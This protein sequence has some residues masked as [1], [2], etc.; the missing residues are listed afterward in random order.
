MHRRQG[1]GTKLIKMFLALADI[2]DEEVYLSAR[3]V[4]NVTKETLERLDK[5]YMRFGFTVRDGGLT[6][7]HMKRLCRSVKSRNHTS[8][9]ARFTANDNNL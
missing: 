7:V 9:G 1:I 2:E 5:Y 8:D 6:V 4:G 3:P